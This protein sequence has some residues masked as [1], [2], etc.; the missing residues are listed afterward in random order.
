MSARRLTIRNAARIPETGRPSMA[1]TRLAASAL[2]LEL[3]GLLA[4]ALVGI[5][6]LSALATSPRADVLLYDGDSVLP[7]LVHASLATGQAQD[8]ALSSVLF[9]P[10]LAL[11][12]PIVALVTELGGSASAALVVAGVA[13]L[14]LLY[15]ALRFVAAAARLPRPA[16]VAGPALA[17][18]LFALLTALD[19]SPDRN[20][21]ELAS[22]STTHT[23]YSATVIAVVLQV[24]AVVALLDERSTSRRG[25]AAVIGLAG[26]TAVSTLSNPIVLAWGVVPLLLVVVV[27]GLTGRTSRRD[28][29]Q[30][31]VVLVGASAAGMLARLPLGGP[32]GLIG[33][34]GAEKL[35][36]AHAGESAAAYGRLLTALV[37]EGRGAATVVLVVLALAAAVALTV[38]TARQ[39][40]AALPAVVAGWAAPLIVVVGAIAAGTE[41]ARYLQPVVFA[42]LLAVAVAPGLLSRLRSGLGPEFESDPESAT[43]SSLPNEH[44]PRPVR[45]LR[46]VGTV[47]T[48]G[49][50]VALLALAALAVTSLAGARQHPVSAQDADTACV[51]AFAESVKGHG[52]GTFWTIRPAKSRLDDPSR[53]IQTDA[54]L[55]RYEWLV[56]RADSAVDRVDYLVT[57]RGETLALPPETGVPS[58]TTECGRYEITV[59]PGGV[60]LGPPHS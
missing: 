28:A 38:I 42:P 14:V 34:D 31:A 40:H 8:W 33:R 46:A 3:A 26:V 59:Y 48:V 24:A 7:L 9:L 35:Q 5:S 23:Y 12:I 10:E 30:V 55:N 1:A 57:G 39:Q 21:L 44:A 45:P 32:D 50:V 41:A 53:L 4:A 25:V 47:G 56:N 15:A 60:P 19:H 27:L 11:S 52:A 18:A 17:T 13:N 58:G 54:A 51:A 20:A 22:L 43:P 2:A 36:P 6:A 49:T 37:G 29:V 16:A